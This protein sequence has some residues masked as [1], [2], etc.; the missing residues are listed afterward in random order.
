MKKTNRKYDPTPEEMSDWTENRPR[1]SKDVWLAKVVEIAKGLPKEDM[2][3]V[4]HYFGLE[5]RKCLEPEPLRKRFPGK[6]GVA[7]RVVF[8]ADEELGTNPPWAKRP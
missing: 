3:F 2:E 1:P 8:D 4:F 7:D 6:V 5:G